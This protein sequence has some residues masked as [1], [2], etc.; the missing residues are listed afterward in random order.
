MVVVDQNI[1]VSEADA[2]N[3]I[4]GLHHSLTLLDFHFPNLAAS[5][6]DVQRTTPTSSPLRRSGRFTP[7]CT[8]LP[9]PSLPPIL[10]SPNRGSSNTAPVMEWCDNNDNN[11][12]DRCGNISTTEG[13]DHIRRVSTDLQVVPAARAR[14]VVLNYT[15]TAPPGYFTQ[16]QGK[17][18][19]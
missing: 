17:N 10:G 14:N 18:R 7:P 3:L 16:N 8:T 19:N 13:A 11:R 12:E 9:P 5:H 6:P 2:V 15:N 4:Y 1:L